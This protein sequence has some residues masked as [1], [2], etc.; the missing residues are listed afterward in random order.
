MT[1]SAP[2]AGS[3]DADYETCRDN[4][5]VACGLLNR[6]ALALRVAGVRDRQQ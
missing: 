1:R 4:D 6:A 3:V 2:Q 5:R